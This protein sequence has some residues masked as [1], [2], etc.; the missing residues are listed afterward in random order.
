MLFD[1]SQCFPLQYAR[2]GWTWSLWSCDLPYSLESLVHIDSLQILS[3]LTSF[4]TAR[5]VLITTEIVQCIQIIKRRKH[6]QR[7][8]LGFCVVTIYMLVKIQK[9]NVL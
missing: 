5:Q 4:E 9:H 8:S 6:K 1:I 3:S 2:G 7:G